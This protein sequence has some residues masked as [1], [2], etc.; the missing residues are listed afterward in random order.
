MIVYYHNVPL[1]QN[2][3]ESWHNRW[4]S[5]LNR[6]K[7]NIFKTIAEFKKEQ[8]NTEDIIE[9]LKAAEPMYKRKREA[10][11][12]Y[13][14]RINRHLSERNEMDLKSYLNGWAHICQLMK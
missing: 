2:A 9:R 1:S 12:Y 3:L 8:K 10:A 5:L 13:R 7:R 11:D 4:N 14:E 6:Q